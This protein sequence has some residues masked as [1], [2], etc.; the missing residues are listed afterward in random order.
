M[1]RDPPF[2]TYYS[3]V[4]TQ[5]PVRWVFFDGGS[6]DVQAWTPGATLPDEQWQLPAYCFEEEDADG[7]DEAEPAE[8]AAVVS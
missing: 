3:D 6:F 7:G 4:E 1:H 2:I 8:E 5:E